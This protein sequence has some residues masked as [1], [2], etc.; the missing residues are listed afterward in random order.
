MS[1]AEWKV[2][3]STA[4]SNLTTEPTRVYLTGNRAF[5]FGGGSR[6][7]S[8]LTSIQINTWNSS[9]HVSSTE[10]VS[11]TDVCPSPHLHVVKRATNT[12][13]GIYIDGG[14]TMRTLVSSPHAS[15]G[16]GYQFRYL[17]N[18]VTPQ[19]IQVTLAQ[20][21]VGTTA[22]VIGSPLPGCTIQLTEINISSA[23]NMWHTA[24]NTRRLTMS[25][26]GSVSTCKTWYTVMALKATAVGFNNAS[27]VR[28]EI[29][30]Q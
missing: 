20:M 22:N 26:G 8:I 29:T 14:A 18:D 12:A 15:R 9:L 23:T 10:A 13:N 2:W 17:P 4:A 27:R 24:Y 16:I 5:A 1:T 28:F 7:S 3:G 19:A 30:F 11:A 25:S 21:W 6:S